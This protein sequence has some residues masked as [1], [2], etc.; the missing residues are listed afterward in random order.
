DFDLAGFAP[1]KLLN[2]ISPISLR[3]KRGEMAF[4]GFCVSKTVLLTLRTSAVSRTK[5]PCE[6]SGKKQP[7]AVLRQQ[8]R[9]FHKPPGVSQQP[10]P[11]KHPKQSWHTNRK[12]R[13]DCPP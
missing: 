2:T 5:P 12:K 8:N 7:L 11:H 1:A 4:S 9:A 3:S 10:H 13:Y 6:A